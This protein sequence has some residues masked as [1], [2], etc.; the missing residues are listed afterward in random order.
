VAQIGFRNRLVR[1]ARLAGVPLSAPLAE[2]LE[3]YYR[4]LASWNAKINLTGFKLDDPSA[5]AVDRLFIE[6][7][8]AAALVQPAPTRMLD[9]GSGGG[10]PAIPMILAVP[11]VRATMVESKTRKSVFLRE[12]IRSLDLE[13]AE[14]ITSRIEE[15]LTRPDLHD[16]YDL[17]TIRAVRL[18]PALLATLQAFLRSRGAILLFGPA[19]PDEPIFGAPGLEPVARHQ[20][21]GGSSLV[22]LRKRTGTGVSR[23]T[24]GR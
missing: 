16:A 8:V 11:G 18:E 21:P 13:S 23:G 17:V 6:P 7:L 10:S 24:P 5:E 14:V 3:Q 19:A 15:L 2:A 9:V 1:R 12:V 4:L 22:V 20:L